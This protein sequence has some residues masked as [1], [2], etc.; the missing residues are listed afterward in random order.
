MR[1]SR[2]SW[3]FL[4]MSVTCLVLLAPTPEKYRWVNLS[5]AALSLMWFVAFAVG[6][7]AVEQVHVGQRVQRVLGSDR[8]HHVVVP[9]H[10]ALVR[11]DELQ[12]RVPGLL[13]D[14]HVARP[15]LGDPRVPVLELVD[16]PLVV[17]AARDPV[18]LLFLQHGRS[19]GPVVRRRR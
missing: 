4:G 5:M 18:V 16:V 15:C 13:G 10:H 11:D 8:D 17:V 19:L 3:F 14:E 7:F 9:V 12:L 1:L 2:R 6:L